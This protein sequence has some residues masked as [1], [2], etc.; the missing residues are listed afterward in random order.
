MMMEILPIVS[1]PLKWK[2]GWWGGWINMLHFLPFFTRETT[3][4][5]PC[6]LSCTP[7]P[8][9]SKVFPCRGD[10]FF[11]KGSK[12]GQ[13]ASH[14]NVSYLLQYWSTNMLNTLTLLKKMCIAYVVSCLC[15]QNYLLRALIASAYCRI[16]LSHHV[17]L[18]GTKNP[19]SK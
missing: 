12:N 15:A 14:E 6:M 16:S 2:L 5:T 19:P 10:P 3:F 18:F 13:I 4:V 1:S 11:Q 8:C 17:S 7:T 9:G